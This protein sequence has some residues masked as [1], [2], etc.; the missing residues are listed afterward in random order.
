MGVRSVVVPLFALVVVA[1]SLEGGGLAIDMVDRPAEAV[2]PSDR[3]DATPPS[4]AS[5]PTRPDARAEIDTSVVVEADAAETEVE[6]GFDPCPEP[7]AIRDG[8][9]CY[10]RIE[11]K[12]NWAS[13]SSDCIDRGAHLVT[14]GGAAEQA[15]VSQLAEDDVWIGL[16]REKGSAGKKDDF[17]WIDKGKKEFDAW[18]SGEPTAGENELCSRLRGGDKKWAD[19]DCE[20]SFGAVCERD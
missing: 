5:A 7:G 9:H 17:A 13:A 15:L 10:F 20:A 2:S 1:C 14:I 6:S 3:L 12:Q 18:G 11:K 4:D 8:A 16:R 19:F